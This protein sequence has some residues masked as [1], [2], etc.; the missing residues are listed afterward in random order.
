MPLNA[1]GPLSLGG[2]TVGES[3]NLE[4]GKSAT[5]LISMNDSDLRTL[6][7]VAS[8]QISM[9]QGYGKSS[10]S[11]ASTK[12]YHGGGNPSRWDTS[13]LNQIDGIQFSNEAAIDPA[14]ALAQARRSLA[15]VNNVSKGYFVGGFS[16]PSSL[17][18]V[19]QIDGIQF[20]NEAAI[21]PAAA[22]A[23]ARASLSG[24]NSS[25]KGYFAG[26]ETSSSNL[27]QI[28]GIQFSDEAAI[29][30]A[31]ALAQARGALSGVNSS[32]RG[33]FAGGFAPGAGAVNQIDGIQFSDETAI[34]PAAALVQGR[35]RKSVVNS[36]TRGYFLGGETDE[37]TLSQL[38]GIQFS[39]EA[40]I[41][42]AASLGMYGAAGTNSSTRGYFGGG[43]SSP[44][45]LRTNFQRLEFSAET[46]TQLGAII[47]QTRAEMPGVQN[48]NN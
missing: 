14:A 13:Q 10:Y 38:D 24:V 4:L 46:F 43:M 5:A 35:A 7:G 32:T 6:F 45:N 11:I 27:T 41:D 16:S 47:T 1:S 23:Q 26:G 15:G 33:Y 28:D 12:G 8:G 19:T 2:S 21:D 40:A 17:S 37:P 34:D 22:L 48:S 42:P 39:N 36:S 31:A 30:P 20:S 9:S 3:V 44:S 18:I 25:T 29:D